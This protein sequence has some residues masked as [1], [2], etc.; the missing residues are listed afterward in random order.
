MI[1]VVPS[2]LSSNKLDR[3]FYARPTLDVARDLIGKIV[4][5][6]SQRNLLMARIVEVE[7]YIG[8]NDPA[9]HAAVGRTKRNEIMF[10]QP[11][12]AYIYLIYGM[13]NCLNFV[14]E[15]EGFPAAVLLRAAEPIEGIESMKRRS[16]G[17]SERIML[18]GPGKFCR[19]FGLTRKQNG[20]D[21]TGKRLYLADLED[22]VA[23]VEKRRRI[24]ISKGVELLY[25]FIDSNSK[26]LSRK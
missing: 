18:S 5:Y 6:H 4:V 10:G 17:N 2:E 16:S 25:R 15:C 7:A 12:L 19:A 20:L 8:E 21:L 22:C 23:V 11:G 1:S 14:T 24:G 13:Y 3:A 26:S 9:C